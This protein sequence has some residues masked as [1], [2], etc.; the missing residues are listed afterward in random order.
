VDVR[1]TSTAYTDP[2]H[3]LGADLLVFGSRGLGTPMSH[4]PIYEAAQTL[5]LTNDY[6]LHSSD[7]S[8]WLSNKFVRSPVDPQLF[9][10][11][12][13]KCS[14]K[15]LH[16]YGKSWVSILFP[17]R[18][19]T[20]QVA[21]AM[22]HTVLMQQ[23]LNASHMSAAELS[24]HYRVSTTAITRWVRQGCPVVRRDPYIFDLKAVEAWKSTNS[25]ENQQ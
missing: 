5:P 18:S 11:G 12:S 25:T 19:S 4:R 2:R 1:A 9:L 8:F 13:R 10:A 6:V 24:H 22:C 15:D 23:V 3:A 17:R 14:E 7:G 21:S 16:I 20:L